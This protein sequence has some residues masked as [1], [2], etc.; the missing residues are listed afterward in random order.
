MQEDLS[1]EHIARI[2]ANPL[3][4]LGSVHPECIEPREPVM[5]E[6]AFVKA[7]VEFIKQEGAE[8]YI[9]LLLQNLKDP[10][11]FGYQQVPEGV[12]A[13]NCCHDGMDEV[14][15]KEAE[16][17]ESVG[18]YA[19]MVQDDPD[20]PTGM[21]YHTHG[22]PTSFNHTDFQVCAF[23]DP[24]A[25]HSV[26]TDLIENIKTGKT[27]EAGEIVEGILTEGFTLTFK[28][29][30]ECGRPVLRIILPD[31]NGC[32]KQDEMEEPWG[33]QWK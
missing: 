2:I 19:H 27:Y 26:V 11:E 18:W 8:A 6:D 15:L 17:M 21:N 3:Y 7:G 20:Y 23:I 12:T 9:R 33:E 32:L 30:S 22:L 24:R 28:A 4:C 31:K 29:T 10:I 1:P 25:I 13:C 14:L 16:N 5:S